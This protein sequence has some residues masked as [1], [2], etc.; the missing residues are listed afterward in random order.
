MKK[1]TNQPTRCMKAIRST[2]CLRK[3]LAL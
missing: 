2:E 3:V 1:Q